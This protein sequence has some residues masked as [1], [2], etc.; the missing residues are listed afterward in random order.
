MAVSID[1][2]DLNPARL[3]LITDPAQRAGPDSLHVPSLPYSR[4]PHRATHGPQL[5]DFQGQ[6][7]SLRRKIAGR[8]AP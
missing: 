4:R 8:T 3:R 2:L 7:R 1:E 6:P 5:R